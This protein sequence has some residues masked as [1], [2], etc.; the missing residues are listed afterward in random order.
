LWFF[1]NSGLSQ[2][3]VILSHLASPLCAPA[4]LIRKNFR[5]P[6]EFFV[7]LYFAALPF[8]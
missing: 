6:R 4:R 3:T 8:L 1:K 2:G 7:V 5:R